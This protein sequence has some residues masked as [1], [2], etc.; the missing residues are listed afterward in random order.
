M[1]KMKKV[2][3]LLLC[4]AMLISILPMNVFSADDST[5]ETTATETVKILL[6]S[7]YQNSSTE[8]V[9]STT[10]AI[11]DQVSKEHTDINGFLFGGDYNYNYDEATCI[12]GQ[13]ALQSLVKSYYS[14]LA[15][16][17]MVFIQGNHD[18]PDGGTY[19]VASG[20]Q[21]DMAYNNA[22]GVFVINEQD[23]MWHNDDQTKIKE[24]AANLETYLADKLDDNYEKPIFIMSHLPLHYSLRT[25]VGGG[26]GRY[27]CYIY[28]VLNKY[29]GLGLNIFFL[30]GHNHSHGWDDYLGGS[31]IFLAKGDPMLIAKEGSLTEYDTST[32]NFT[33]MNYGY[34]GYYRDVNDGAETDLTMTVAEISGNSVT[35]TR[36]SADGKHDLAS[37]GVLNTSHH[38]DGGSATC[39]N[40]RGTETYNAAERTLASPY[41]VTLNTGLADLP[42]TVTDV[43]NTVTVTT[44]YITGVSI[45][46]VT[47]ATFPTELRAL[48]SYDITLTGD[49]EEGTTATVTIKVPEG[50]D[51]LKK[52]TIWDGPYDTGT[53]IGTATI[54][55]GA[56][57]FT[58]THFS[59]YSL[60]QYKATTNVADDGKIYILAGSD[61][62]TSDGYSVSN[63]TSI[64]NT[65][66]ATYTNNGTPSL[67][68]L[69][70]FLFAGDFAS[71]SANTAAAARDLLAAVEDV[72]T[73]LPNDGEE[74]VNPILVQG[75]T[76]SVIDSM[77]PTGGQHLNGYGVYVINEDA[78]PLDGGNAT[79]MSTLGTKLYNY[80]HVRIR[81]Y[82]NEPVFVV[83]HIPLHYTGNT[84][85]TGAGKYAQ[86]LFE[87]LNNAGHAGLNIVYLYG[88]HN[89]GTDTDLQINATTT[90][91]DGSAV[92][93][94][95][96]SDIYVPK[97]NAQGCDV[98]TLQFTYMNAGYVGS[99]N[100]SDDGTTMTLFSITPATG[101]ATCEITI[102][103]FNSA[104][105]AA[106][107]VT[108]VGTQPYYENI[109]LYKGTG[110]DDV[111]IHAVSHH[112]EEELSPKVKSIVY[113]ENHPYNHTYLED[114]TNELNYS[115]YKA[116]DIQVT[117]NVMASNGFFATVMIAYPTSWPASS[118]VV[119]KI[120]QLAD[121]SYEY[122]TVPHK[123]SSLVED[124]AVTPI[125]S[126]RAFDDGIYAI[127]CRQDQSDTA[128]VQY[129]RAD[130]VTDITSGI[131]L[132]SLDASAQETTDSLLIPT[133]TA[134]GGIITEEYPNITQYQILGV[135]AYSSA[136]EWELIYTAEGTRSYYIA[137]TMAD[138]V[139]KEYM[140]VDAA[141]GAVS[142]VSDS[143]NADKFQFKSVTDG[144]T[145]P[146]GADD[147]AYQIF[148]E[149]EDDTVLYL[150]YNVDK[151]FVYGSTT[152]STQSRFVLM[153]RLVFD[154]TL[155]VTISNPTVGALK[156]LSG[157]ASTLYTYD[158]VTS[159]TSGNNY[160]I[161]APDASYALDGYQGS[162]SAG[163]IDI[164]TSTTI[165]TA[166][167]ALE[168]T[169]TTTTSG[170]TTG[171]R[172]STVDKDGNTQYLR[173]ASSTSGSGWYQTTTYSLGL[174][175]DSSS[176]TVWSVSWYSGAA[177][178]SSTVTTTSNRPNGSTSTTYYLTYNSSTH[179]F[180]SSSSSSS[181]RNLYLYGNR[182]NP[183]ASSNLYGLADPG[184]HSDEYINDV[185]Y[186]TNLDTPI[187][188]I[189]GVP[190]GTSEELAKLIAMDD[191]IVYTY[192]SAA[193]TDRK[194]L[195]DSSEY[196]EWNFA[197]EYHP[198][199]PGSY[200]LSIVYTP[201]GGT[202]RISLGTVEVVV[203]PADGSVKDPVSVPITTLDD[204]GT[205]TTQNYYLSL[206]GQ[207]TYNIGNNTFTTRDS[208]LAYIQSNIDVLRSEE[209]DADGNPK[210][211]VIISDALVSWD[212]A[213]SDMDPTVAGTYMLNISYKYTDGNGEQQTVPLGTVA[214]NITEKKVS[215]VALSTYTGFV[216]QG[217]PG[218]TIIKDASGNNVLLYVTYTDGTT[219]SI[220][221]TV[222]MLRHLPA[223]DAGMVEGEVVTTATAGIF[224]ELQAYH[225]G[226]KVSA[227]YFVLHVQARVAIDYPEYPDEGA[228]KVDKTATGVDFQSS[229]V[230]QVELSA[231]GIPIKKGAD[232]IV[233]VDT[234]SSMN[235]N[236]VTDDDGNTMT[237]LAALEASL[238]S[239][240]KIFQTPGADGEL[241]DIRV[242]IADF[243][244]YAGSNTSSPYYLDP[245]DHVGEAYSYSGHDVT[246]AQVYTGT[247]TLSA[248][249]FVDAA[250]LAASYTL[251][252][253]SGTN[254]DYAMDAI[255]QLGTAIQKERK[256]ENNGEYDR[257]L[258]VIFMSDGAPFQWNYYSSH[259]SRE[260]WNYWLT[261]TMTD[262]LFNSSLDENAKV[263]QYYYDT[264][265]WD[266]DGQ[267]NEHRMAN[268]IKG[269]PDKSYPIIRKT[270][271][272][273]TEIDKLYDK[274]GESVLVSEVENM[275]SVPGLGATMF[276]IAFGITADS[277]IT[278]ETQETVI[279]SLATDDVGSTTYTYDVQS[280]TELTAAFQTIAG[281]IAYAASE[282]RFLDQMGD[283]YDLQMTSKTYTIKD[284]N[285]NE[286]TRTIT[287]T[288]EIL[289]Y[290][291]Y[292]MA[293]YNDGI[294]KDID[295][296]GTRKPNVAPTVLETVI[297]SDDGNGNV[298]GAY[299]SLIDTDNDGIAG[300][301][302][303]ADG[304]YTPDPAD[305]ILKDGIICAVTFF[306]NTTSA[307]VSVD[308]VQIPTFIEATGEISDSYTPMLPSETF[309]WNMETIT[310]SELAMRYYV[311]LTGSMEGARNA[312]SYA[313]NNY[314]VLYYTN[315]LDHHAL[316][317]ADSPTV[318][319]K[320]ATVSYA[321]YLVN[322][323]GE[324]VVNQ[325]T[326]MVG[327]FANRI[328]LTTPVVYQEVL[329]NSISDVSAMTVLANAPDVLPNYYNLYDNDASFTIKIKSDG[330]GNWEI[331]KGGDKEAT[332][333]VTGYNGNEYSKEL[334]AT[335]TTVDYT[336]TVV[337]FAVVWKMQSYPDTV[338]I[339][340]GLPV[341][342]NAL[343]NDMFGEYGT[344][345]AIGPYNKD[346]DDDVAQQLY[347]DYRTYDNNV[348]YEGTYGTFML[349]KNNEV[350]YTPTSM[351]MSG[352]EV[353]G[354]AVEYLDPNS[355][356]STRYYYSS[357]TIIPAT[358]IY[359]ED[360]FLDLK[361]FDYTGA[362]LT[363]LW[364]TQSGSNAQQDEDRPGKY[365]L[366]ASDA[367]N[368]FGY[369]SSYTEMATYSMGGYSKITVTEGESY[370]TATFTFS[371][372]GFDVIAVTSNKTGAIT[373]QVKDPT[374]KSVKNT[375]VDAYYGYTTENHKIQYTYDA[376]AG[377]WLSQDLGIDD[378]IQV[379]DPAT[380]KEMTDAPKAQDT[381]YTEEE[382]WVVTNSEDENALYQI[383]VIKVNGLTYGTYT[384][385]ITVLYND[386]FYHGQD[387]TD[388][389]KD[390]VNSYDF[391]LDAIR[392]YDPADI[393]L[394]ANSSIKDAYILDG[395]AWP[396]YRELRDL[397]IDADTFN[398][399]EAGEANGVVYIDGKDKN[400]TMENYT[401]YGPNNEVYLQTYGAVAFKLDL[402]KY[403][404]DGESIVADVQI[405]VKSANGKP[406]IANVFNIYTTETTTNEDG[407]T[408]ETKTSAITNLATRGMATNTEMYY[409]AYS[410]CTNENG[411]VVCLQN[412]GEGIMSV[413]NIKITFTEDPY[414]VADT[415]TISLA[416]ISLE[417]INY[418]VM[419]LSL[420]F[421]E[422][423]VVV[424]DDSESDVTEPDATE[425]DTT[426]PD[427][428]EPDVTEPDITEPDATEPD[429]TEPD[430]TEPDVTEPDVTE[431]DVTEPDATEPVDPN[432]TDPL[433][434]DLSRPDQSEDNT[435]PEESE[436]AAVF[437][438]E[439]ISM[440]A[441]LSSV[442]V[443]S[444]VKLTVTTSADVDH[445]TVNGETVTKFQKS[446]SSRV[447]TVKLTAQSVG[448]M[449]IE[450]VAY[451]SE[452]LASVP[453]V[454][455][456]QVTRHYTS[457]R[458]FFSDVAIFF[459]EFF[460]KEG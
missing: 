216:R 390:T 99:Y 15:V 31:A 131:Y 11:L 317:Y 221:V 457:L 66:K 362:E 144:I 399:S 97:K 152:D 332:T 166:G 51:I 151:T 308:G 237:R 130:L 338:V 282:A 105:H 46:D 326:G 165:Q 184:N 168:W 256:A 215:A 451:N 146:D 139:T 230:A 267:F 423:D 424:P 459:E 418:T 408:T 251:N 104:G 1:E 377:K 127:A 432:L 112:T 421:D 75:D 360:N 53:K 436:P 67:T 320:S 293:E 148:T 238:E 444:T 223:D 351:N 103:R 70:G 149:K 85:V 290:E 132:I 135:H 109:T 303:N 311:Y 375:L 284:S 355:N 189:Y 412:T 172:I 234:S 291:L 276:S 339:D 426:E 18:T 391:Y 28:D 63:V 321:F 140:T 280:S 366:S 62:K 110:D 448:D 161:A 322:E 124:G 203:L 108:I 107:E 25:Q 76:D 429:A 119:Y 118:L 348:G 156:D 78:F 41:T 405:G 164:S 236:N 45:K 304:T 443:G 328:Q 182:S 232:V 265:D 299:S 367:N 378:T 309:Y 312:G 296:V 167:T 4:V 301:T 425:P 323:K 435:V 181:S 8:T 438:P 440:K 393:S 174:T 176:A 80:L 266:G 274:K 2:L 204:E 302:V 185:I 197:D 310:T 371:G 187:E 60:S 255:Y 382:V 158:R 5:T 357:I 48:A 7:D 273:G 373:V 392:I 325:S 43:T 20:D 454:G 40:D 188:G 427:V 307:S 227:N 101:N 359:Y 170:N 114:L 347:D 352:P 253:K 442:K 74:D 456:I 171:Y 394:E 89:D 186:G 125:L 379:T 86:Y 450:L 245:N 337:W 150:S 263:H 208:L 10:A 190:N 93:L 178:I 254:Y 21:D 137:R 428:T 100:G 126:L 121:G 262:E 285:G 374:G 455:T 88:H 17:N 153:Q 136:Y 191:I 356:V 243:N 122:E 370:G 64:L 410:Q 318:A 295:L 3:S 437:T 228:V 368:V 329:L 220:P 252:Y 224:Y 27:A 396:S 257:D 6:G 242:A 458:N 278:K 336:H 202:T 207:M 162:L 91:A 411:Y 270:A 271:G 387:G 177:R 222:D 305:N 277:T 96:H 404:K 385:T 281:Q 361:T 214:V 213:D 38:T 430:A 446:G 346:Y 344:I 225:N 24:T 342:I 289:S 210:S 314:A 334:E 354:Y 133:T 297:F 250:D 16:E 298:T 102:Q 201:N 372:T 26:D 324:P 195:E 94:P 231:S 142:F 288:I 331:K 287:P 409:S 268:A 363:N 47:P 389:Y 316:L 364:V 239:M 19:F 226:E 129:H 196:L 58:T 286:V 115:A 145:N 264:V 272:L 116:F 106:N 261:G 169:F 173:L 217:M 395:E 341:S 358:S 439:A 81:D 417:E 365:S 401:S 39:C 453:Y 383:P 335:D 198:N 259:S 82:P 349:D 419:A 260:A 120:N 218:S 32:L 229:G 275:Y 199:V 113:D 69:G 33:Y 416:S 84:D 79:T 420:A 388:T 59:T 193:L 219:V 294:I 345:V 449:D 65:I 206:Q 283:A 141:T 56:V 340:Y 434:P 71:S 34:V 87:M 163:A 212:W 90:I 57:T 98:R 50:F 343:L 42:K 29:G 319:W 292:T 95:I 123:I 77:A 406:I 111:T 452:G 407:T 315:Y 386:L 147:Y 128:P 402:S 445:I 52:V 192:T 72:F 313:T 398:E 36:Y 211:P 83:S 61:L 269:D 415:S 414:G 244:Q 14:D 422:P 157:L 369:D 92:Y 246:N 194:D 55:N 37:K 49:Y 327:S 376:E 413:T 154:A 400:V 138:G 12:S 247:N 447:W 30:F 397:L 233:M 381:Y 143:A 384:V 54:V 13:S 279:H 403:M 441:R 258:F 160:V 205:A 241:L 249:A 134:D 179:T 155:G 380:I 73:L 353:V 433:L 330:T 23:Y 240:I 68:S 175:T 183:T 180:S 350:V 235:S 35:F 200:T 333:Y 306:Y 9:K 248:G 300:F 159:I 460:K 22:Y 431:P 117:E 44:P 209:L